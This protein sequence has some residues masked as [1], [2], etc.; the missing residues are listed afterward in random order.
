LPAGKGGPRQGA[1]SICTENVQLWHPYL[2]KADTSKTFEIW[3]WGLF[4][5]EISILGSE[6]TFN[7]VESLIHSQPSC[8]IIRTTADYFF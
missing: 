4:D 1:L 7:I 2:A 8:G 5:V 6:K 3:Y